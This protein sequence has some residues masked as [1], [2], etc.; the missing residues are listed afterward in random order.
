MTII[1]TLQQMCRWQWIKVDFY[2]FFHVIVVRYLQSLL[3][4][5]ARERMRDCV[6]VPIMELG[7]Y[8]S[9]EQDTCCFSEQSQLGN[10]HADA[11][12]LDLWKRWLVA[13]KVGPPTKINAKFLDDGR[14]LRHGSQGSSSSGSK[15]GR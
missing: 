15:Q 5:H 6:C 2:V 12:I 14:S 9:P 11:V 3:W 4:M 8:L 7:W 10:C 1:L 13:M